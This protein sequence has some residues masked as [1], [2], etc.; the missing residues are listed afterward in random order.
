MR[1]ISSLLVTLAALLLVSAPLALAQGTYT[2]IDVPGAAF[3]TVCIGI[4]TA[5]EIVGAYGTTA[6]TEDGFLL[7]GGTYTTID[8]PGSTITSLSGINDLGDIVG[9]SRDPDVGFLYD[10]QSQT[11]TTISF[12]HA[13]QTFPIAIN[14]AGDIVGQVVHGIFSL[15]FE[16][17]GSRYKV[18][19][20]PRAS[21]SGAFG[22]TASGEVFGTASTR[23]ATFDF[24]FSQGNYSQFSIPGAP[25][26]LV[27]GVNPAG[28]AVVGYYN[29]S[30]EVAA[31]F[32]Y[33]NKTL[34]TL[35][36]PGSNVTYAYGISDAGEVVGTFT[37]ASF[38]EHGFTWTPAPVKKK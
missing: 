33:Q 19:L 11:F 15:G 7:S 28:T 35:Q 16:L 2:Q 12:P 4:D 36:F 17:V 25:G 24:A 10:V 14:N 9:G 1:R 30:S 22:I 3:G 18:I 29:P 27:S 6:G 31:G 23:N 38:N 5:G 21:T 13:S 34:T 8:Y 26:A 20:P 37:D 32:V